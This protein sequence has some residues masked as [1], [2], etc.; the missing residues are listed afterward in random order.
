MKLHNNHN[1]DFEKSLTILKKTNDKEIA[2]VYEKYFIYKEIL[3]EG[4]DS[5]LNKKDD[6]MNNINFQLYHQLDST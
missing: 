2:Q 1:I 5:M 4:E 3:E 6:F